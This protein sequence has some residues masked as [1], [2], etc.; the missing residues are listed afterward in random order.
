[1]SILLIIRPECT[2]AA[3]HAAPS[4]VTEQTERRTDVRQLHYAFR[5]RRGQRKNSV[6][7]T[8]RSCTAASSTVLRAI[9]T[10]F[11]QRKLQ[12]TARHST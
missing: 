2:L 10:K 11:V 5:Y 8:V 1:M 3:S 7:Q 9:M 12:Q 6:W 4:W